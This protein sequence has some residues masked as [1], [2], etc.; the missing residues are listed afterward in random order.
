MNCPNTIVDGC[1]DET[2][3]L[4]ESYKTIEERSNMLVSE[5]VYIGTF[6]ITVTLST[7]T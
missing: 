6:M 3:I 7:G 1:Q 2:F 5:I 4:E